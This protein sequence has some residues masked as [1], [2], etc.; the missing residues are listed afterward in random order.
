MYRA[1]CATIARFQEVV[2]LAN[3][4]RELGY[5]YSDNTNLRG[6]A[7]M[8]ND[9]GEERKGPSVHKADLGRGELGTQGTRE[10]GA[11]GEKGRKP[12]SYRESILKRTASSS[13]SRF[14][15][16]EIYT[17]AI[18]H[19]PHPLARSLALSL[20]RLVLI[21]SIPDRSRWIFESALA[22]RF[23]LC[24][25]GFVRPKNKFVIRNHPR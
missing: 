1:R 20:P 19:K 11:R 8:N 12:C 16:L 7:G 3:E 6:A 21:P 15:G 13:S 14:L 18:I 2:R 4:A 9:R 25:G 17:G 22:L 24:E 5:K 10:Q 23:G